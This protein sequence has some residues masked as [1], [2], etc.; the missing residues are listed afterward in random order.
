MGVAAVEARPVTG[1]DVTLLFV[2]GLEVR[3]DRGDL[4]RNHAIGHVGQPEDH[5]RA[6]T[7]RA[8]LS[9]ECDVARSVIDVARDAHRLRFGRF[10]RRGDGAVPNAMT[11]RLASQAG[12]T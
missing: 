7:L 4:G 5:M 6:G 10:Q 11:N 2:L 3:G 1:M 8:E 12:S 9:Y